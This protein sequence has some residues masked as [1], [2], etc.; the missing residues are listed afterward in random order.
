VP[1]GVHVVNRFTEDLKDAAVAEAVG[2][3]LRSTGGALTG[4]A[5]TTLGAFVV[6]AFSSLPPIRALG[7]LGGAGIAFALLAA[8][9]VEPG[10]LVLAA[11]RGRRPVVRSGGGRG[12]LS[13]A[14]ASQAGS[15]A[16]ETR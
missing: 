10:A 13:G 9:L 7:L 2:R 1:Y 11:R 8:V 12:R 5:L 3:T 4:S 16:G 15:T 6:L 14:S